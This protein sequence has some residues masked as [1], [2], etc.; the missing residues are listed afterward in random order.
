MKRGSGSRSSTITLPSS[1]YAKKLETSSTIVVPSDSI[2]V[3]YPA[4]STSVVVPS[5]FTVDVYPTSKQSSLLLLQFV[6]LDDGTGDYM[7]YTGLTYLIPLSFFEDKTRYPGAK[8]A[9]KTLCDEDCYKYNNIDGLIIS[10]FVDFDRAFPT[11]EEASTSFNPGPWRTNAMKEYKAKFSRD[12]DVDVYG[13]HRFRLAVE[14]SVSLK[15]KD[16]DFQKWYSKY[17]AIDEDKDKEVTRISIDEWKIKLL[18]SCSSIGKY[19]CIQ[20]PYS[21]LHKKKM[22]NQIINLD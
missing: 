16:I 17:F 19:V 15:G 22:I 13:W 9:F 21:G 11:S 10:A 6:H 7:C 20:P 3:V 5:D 2:V 4:A 1:K 8:R 12:F 14:G 18:S